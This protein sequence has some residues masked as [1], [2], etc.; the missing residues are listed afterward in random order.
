MRLK[1]SK[2]KIQEHGCSYGSYIS[3]AYIL[4]SGFKFSFSG[5]IWNHRK[6]RDVF[7]RSEAAE[8]V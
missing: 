1:I 6:D 8:S 4:C 2:E 7:E 3:C 5:R